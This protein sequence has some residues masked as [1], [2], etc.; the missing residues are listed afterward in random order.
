[1]NLLEN[2]GYTI[3]ESECI[4]ENLLDYN[5]SFQHRKKHILECL[6]IYNKSG[7]NFEL[8]VEKL[9]LITNFPEEAIRE[10]QQMLIVSE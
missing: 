4:I 9:K 6:K 10:L 3:E 1:M 8:A 7:I 2:S 5:L